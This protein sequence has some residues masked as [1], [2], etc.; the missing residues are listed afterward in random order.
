M[1]IFKKKKEL[2]SEPEFDKEL[3]RKQNETEQLDISLDNMELELKDLADSKKSAYQEK[4]ETLNQTKD[5]I[6]D[7]CNQIADAKKQ[8]QEAKLEYKAVTDYLADIQKID[9]IEGK[10][11]EELEDAARNIIT[12]TRER[13][14]YQTADIKLS[15]VQF[16]N[17]SR[18]EKNMVREIRQMRENEDYQRMVKGDLRQLAAEKAKLEFERDE[19]IGGQEML[20]KLSI[21]AGI[22]VVLMDIIFVVLSEK[23]ELD[24]NVPFIL[25]IIF[26][27][28]IA[29]YI[30]H[31][32]RRNR[33]EILKNNQKRSRLVGLTNTVK[34]KYVNTQ[35]AL[36][37]AYGKF[38]VV[39]SMELSSVYDKYMKAKKEAEQYRSNTGMLNFYNNALI[40]ELRQRNIK[41]CDI[42]IYQA[43]ALIDNREMVEIRHRLNERR[44]KLRERI[45]FNYKVQNNG[46]SMLKNSMEKKPEWKQKVEEEMEKAGIDF[47]QMELSE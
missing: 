7:T 23:K 24:L 16:R 34:I 29:F 22:L 45:D 8:I 31:E 43:A 9:A 5:S 32:S 19:I 3:E 1:K 42:W 15:D 18:Y 26:A 38:M 41:D 46:L 37:Y 17:I 12:L 40:K 30:F 11:R 21:A 2:H 20:R 44:Q 4:E 47:Q 27:A 28:G 25:S 6:A 36:D 14:K 33:M 13:S 10:E 35:N 39:N